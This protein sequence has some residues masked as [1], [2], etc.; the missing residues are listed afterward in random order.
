MELPWH[1]AITMLAVKIKMTFEQAIVNN[2]LGG[3]NVHLYVAVALDAVAMLFTI[4][5]PV[6]CASGRNEGRD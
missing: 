5:V 6:V 1:I 4:R 2:C 3:C